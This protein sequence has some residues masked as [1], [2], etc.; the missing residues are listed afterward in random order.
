MP[1]TNNALNVRREPPKI[2][3]LKLLHVDDENEWARL[4]DK[5]CSGSANLGHMLTDT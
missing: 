3:P 5:L 2:A 4:V 1:T